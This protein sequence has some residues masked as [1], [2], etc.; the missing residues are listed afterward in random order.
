MNNQLRIGEAIG[1]ISGGFIL[2]EL[3]IKLSISIAGLINLIIVLMII[4]GTLRGMKT[5]K[6]AF[7]VFFA[8]ILSI[9]CGVLFYL[10]GFIAFEQ[11]SFASGTLG[12]GEP[13]TNLLV[14]VSLEA[15]L[16]LIAAE[17]IIMSE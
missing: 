14:G 12:V 11:Y 8:G 15:I 3:L 4:I 1:L 9:I 17:V 16:A 13:L 5:R 10:T 6:V 7:I 2:I